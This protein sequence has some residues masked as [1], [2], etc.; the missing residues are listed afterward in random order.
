MRHPCHLP[1]FASLMALAALLALASGRF[2]LAGSLP[3]TVDGGLGSQV[4]NYALVEDGEFTNSFGQR[5]QI[6][7]WDR[8]LNENQVLRVRSASCPGGYRPGSMM[9][10]EIDRRIIPM[11]SS[12]LRFLPSEPANP[13]ALALADRPPASHS[14]H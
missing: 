8:P 1:F 12:H 9:G 7:A 6:Y 11:A 3:L 4:G 13:A 14:G 5:C 2:A 10:T